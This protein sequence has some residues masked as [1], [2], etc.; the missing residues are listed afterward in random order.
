[1]FLLIERVTTHH[2]QVKLLKTQNK[3][4]AYIIKDLDKEKF[5]GKFFEKELKIKVNTFKLNFYRSAVMVSF[6]IELVSSIFFSIV[7][8][9][10][11]LVLLQTFHQ[12]K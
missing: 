8:R 10:I 5:Q 3:P 9:M 7:T 4:P 11:V 12:K 1:M 2:S 6:I